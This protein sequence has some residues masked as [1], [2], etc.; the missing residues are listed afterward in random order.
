MVSREDNYS[1]RPLLDDLKILQRVKKEKIDAIIAFAKNN[2]SCK[3]RQLLAY[4][5]ELKKENCHSCS[6]TSCYK[7]KQ[8]DLSFLQKKILDLLQENHLSAHELKL[9]SCPV[10][11]VSILAKY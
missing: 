10:K 11:K 1:L 3:Q 6:A 5:G 7:I 2:T 9:S 4:F 8:I